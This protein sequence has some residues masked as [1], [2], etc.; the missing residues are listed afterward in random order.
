MPSRHV[1]VGRCC[2]KKK[3]KKKV[4]PIFAGKRCVVESKESEPTF[5]KLCGTHMDWVCC[6]PSWDDHKRFLPVGQAR[7]FRFQNT[8]AQFRCDDHGSRR[9][10]GGI[11]RFD[12]S[13]RV[14]KFFALSGHRSA[15]NLGPCWL[16]ID[17]IAAR[18]TSSR[19]Q[20]GLIHL[21]DHCGQHERIGRI[22]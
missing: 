16:E 9:Q 5:K 13:Y 8:R 19:F 18:R 20:S 11:D 21:L 3:K 22:N 7:R 15:T 2:H 12:F 6:H 17:N 4:R 10:R 14:V 1:Q